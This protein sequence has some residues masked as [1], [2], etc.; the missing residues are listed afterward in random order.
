MF[1]GIFVLMSLSTRFQVYSVGVQIATRYRVANNYMYIGS[2]T[3][4]MMKYDEDC[5]PR[6]IK[7]RECRNSL[8]HSAGEGED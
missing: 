4:K 5:I 8:D 3:L 7:H 6:R 1:L 2:S